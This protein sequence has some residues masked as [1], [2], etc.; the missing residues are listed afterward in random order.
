VIDL[1]LDVLPTIATDHGV[2]WGTEHTSG[3]EEVLAKNGL[4]GG[5]Q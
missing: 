4:G 3:L 1:I 2:K 5:G